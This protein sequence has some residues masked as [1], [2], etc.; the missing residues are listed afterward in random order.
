VAAGLAAS[1]TAAVRELHRS[2][3]DELEWINV[4]VRCLR[5]QRAGQWTEER[6]SDT[7]G[8]STGYCDGCA[9]ARRTQLKDSLP[10]FP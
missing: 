7:A 6:A 9:R 8:H 5:I 4:C 10:N 3:S 2:L 1:M